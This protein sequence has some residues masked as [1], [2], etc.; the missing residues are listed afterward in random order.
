MENLQQLI[1]WLTGV[2]GGAFLVVSAF[3][4]WYL[5]GLSWWARFTRQ[6]KSFLILGAS[7]VLGIGFKVLGAFPAV[8]AAIDPYARTVIF[9]LM[10]W[11]GTQVAHKIDPSRNTVTSTKAWKE[12]G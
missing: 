4:A 1:A 9:I 11:L 5:E 10:V 6:G 3:A 8:V 7:I 12:V 2:D